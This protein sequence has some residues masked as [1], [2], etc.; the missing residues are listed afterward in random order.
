MANPYLEPSARYD[1][2]SVSAGSSISVVTSVLTPVAIIASTNPSLF[3]PVSSPVYN[4]NDGNTYVFN[5]TNWAVLS[6][7]TQPVVAHDITI[8]VTPNTTNKFRGNFGRGVSVTHINGT[9]VSPG[10]VV[11]L[12]TSGIP[13]ARY[14][15]HSNQSIT[16]NPTEF[17]DRLTVGDEV[18]VSTPY[19][20]SDGITSSTANLTAIIERPTAALS[21]YNQTMNQIY[22]LDFIQPSSRYDLRSYTKTVTAPNVTSPSSMTFRNTSITIPVVA[23]ND[24]SCLMYNPGD[25]R[26]YVMRRDSTTSRTLCTA[27]MASDLTISI[28]PFLSESSLAIGNVGAPANRF[29]SASAIDANAGVAFLCNTNATN[30]IDFACVV[31]M[32]GYKANTIPGIYGAG[33]VVP[34]RV[35]NAGSVAL[36]NNLIGNAMTWSPK[37]DRFYSIAPSGAPLVN[38]VGTT[39]GAAGS[40]YL[41]EHRLNYASYNPTDPT[42]YVAYSSSIFALTMPPAQI[43]TNSGQLVTGL[44]VDGNNSMYI[45]GKNVLPATRTVSM[46][47]LSLSYLTTLSTT[48]S[49]YRKLDDP[50]LTSDNSNHATCNPYAPSVTESPE[51]TLDSPIPLVVSLP[52]NRYLTYQIG[53]PAILLADTPAGTSIM[54]PRSLAGTSTAIRSLNVEY[55]N[56]PTTTVVAG[57]IP[58]PIVLSTSTFGNRTRL[59]FTG[60]SN[61][62]NFTTLLKSITFSTTYPSEN[63][64]E[65]DVWVVGA[66]GISSAIRKAYINIAL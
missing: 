27:T 13:S 11:T 9:A 53:G 21:L 51:I 45:F 41:I 31:T 65:I 38:G 46:S 59:T 7:A 29:T 23:E 62:L 34:V 30:N 16:F 35:N 63:E 47:V 19:T 58:A 14:V 10:G 64:V 61:E 37:N 57:T 54:A 12:T 55:V 6:T 20:I 50:V 42:P 3:S 49:T 5:G 26:F 36:M 33:I 32:P 22:K 43:P 39:I 8:R 18:L 1:S 2:I 24:I 66:N 44:C 17:Y 52:Q 48:N 4:T 56:F 40:Y 60:P 28:S 25:G 15:L